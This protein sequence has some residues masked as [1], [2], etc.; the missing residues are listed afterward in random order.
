M[1]LKGR[2]LRSMDHSGRIY[3]PASHR[4][5]MARLNQNWLT[6]FVL[7]KCV[8]ALPADWEE[9][10]SRSSADLD[11]VLFLKSLVPAD[12]RGCCIDKVG[13]LMIPRLMQVA[14]GFKRQILVL[15]CRNR[16]EIWNR[17]VW[18]ATVSCA[19]GRNDS[20]ECAL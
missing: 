6:I 1:S 12:A 5:E 2:F 20:R 17:E 18:A 16:I 3:L 19:A 4:R 11:E 9:V 14:T 13:R 10:A 8:T 15:G 7:D